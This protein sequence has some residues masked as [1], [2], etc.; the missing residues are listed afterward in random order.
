M[1]KLS[2]KKRNA[3]LATTLSAVALAGCTIDS[4]LTDPSNVQCD[5]KRTKVE[6]EG[7]G[8]TTFV[9]HGDKESDVAT[10]QVRRTK[11]IASVAVSEGAQGEEFTDPTP[12]VEG[13]ELNASA[14]GVSWVIDVRDDSV[15]IQGSC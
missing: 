5:G 10:V 8:M 14:A 2:Y 1:E 7:S 13:P 15:V 11:E 9:V 12:V 6:L 4:Y 3:L